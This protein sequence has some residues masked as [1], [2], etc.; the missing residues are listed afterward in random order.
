MP[1]RCEV[2][3]QDRIVYSGNAD[4]VVVPGSDGEMGVLPNHAPLLTLLQFGVVTVKLKN[5]VQH[6]TVSG[7]VAEIQPDQVTILANAAED[8][9]EIDIQ[10]AEHARQR[11]E[12]LM[13]KGLPHDSDEYLN[14][15]SA[16]RRSNLRLDAAKRYRQSQKIRYER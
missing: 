15:Q 2:V 6:F 16:L 12:E 11:V 10:R 9:E 8:V 14:L 4:M 13:Q 3:S 5:E 7:G 1:I